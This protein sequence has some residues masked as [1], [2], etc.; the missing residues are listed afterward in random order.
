MCRVLQLRT[1]RHEPGLPQQ[2]NWA[3]RTQ[4]PH[5]HRGDFGIEWQGF[6][7]VLDPTFTTHLNTAKCNRRRIGFNASHEEKEK[8]KEYN[9]DY[10]L[11]DG[12]FI[13]MGFEI[14]GAWGDEA[15]S[16]LREQFLITFGEEMP[17]HDSTASAVWSQVE[18]TIS[19]ALRTVVTMYLDNI[20]GGA[21]FGGVVV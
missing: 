16:F 6:T 14:R 2:L 13:P 20:R 3:P 8:H 19:K 5:L 7:R 9:R 12:A 1:T 21:A 17:P 4:Q 10:V 11:P 15:Y 18:L